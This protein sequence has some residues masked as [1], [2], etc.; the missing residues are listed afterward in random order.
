MVCVDLRPNTVAA[1]AQQRFDGFDCFLKVGAKG[2]EVVK[3][4][5][6]R[7]HLLEGGGGPHVQQHL[8]LPWVWLYGLAHSIHDVT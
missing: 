8:H 5:K 4:P 2:A 6:Y 3:L 7:L 1:G